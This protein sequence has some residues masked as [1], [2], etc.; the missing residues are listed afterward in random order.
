MIVTD[1]RTRMTLLPLQR[2]IYASKPQLV[3]TGSNALSLVCFTTRSAYYATA[4]AVTDSSCGS[5]A[6]PR[7]DDSAAEP[8][9][10]LLQRDRSVE[11]QRARSAVRVHGEVPQSL[12]LEPAREFPQ[13][14]AVRPRIGRIPMPRL[15]TRQK[16]QIGLPYQVLEAD[17]FTDPCRV[18]SSRP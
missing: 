13:V 1:A 3:F 9:E 12:E 16:L 10:G 5:L 17:L 7:R 2:P 11:H 4:Q 18:T 8:L 14:S 6:A 15:H